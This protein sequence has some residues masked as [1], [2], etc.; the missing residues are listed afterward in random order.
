MKIHYF[1]LFPLCALVINCGYHLSGHGQFLPADAKTIIITDFKNNT[2]R[3]QVEQFVTLAVKEEFIRRTRL[4]LVDSA[5]RA[6]LVIEG[7][8]DAFDVRPLSYS[9]RAAANLYEVQIVVSVR[10]MNIK[11]N[12]LLFEGSRQN[13]RDSYQTDTGDFFSQETEALKKIADRFGASIVSSI[14]ENY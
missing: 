12:E 4:R 9:D 2:S 14:L 10:L 13:F 11:T 5:S 8:V 1:L 6:D 3:F 7:Q